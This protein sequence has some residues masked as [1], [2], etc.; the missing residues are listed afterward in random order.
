MGLDHKVRSLPEFYR[1]MN[2]ITRYGDFLNFTENGIQSK[3][4]FLNFTE[5]GIESQGKV[6]S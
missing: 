3:V 2:Q 5:Y 4:H 1:K 6:T